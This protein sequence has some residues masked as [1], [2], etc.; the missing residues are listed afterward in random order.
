MRAFL[1]GTVA[2]AGL[3]FV[4]MATAAHACAPIRPGSNVYDC[5]SK[6]QVAEERAERE[7]QESAERAA[8]ALEQQRAEYRKAQAEQERLALARSAEEAQ[9][10]A[11]S[12]SQSSPSSSPSRPVRVTVQT[13]DRRSGEK[14]K[15]KVSPSRGKRL[16]LFR[17]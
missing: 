14:A 11:A 2:F 4:S 12:D 13:E 5:R 7:R 8:M 1:I 9:S 3:A 6:A 16:R 10:Q 15:P 17:R